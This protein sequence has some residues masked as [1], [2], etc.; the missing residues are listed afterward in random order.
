MKKMLVWVTQMNYMTKDLPKKCH[1]SFRWLN[2]VSVVRDTMME[3]IYKNNK[4]KCNLFVLA[5][6]L[7]IIL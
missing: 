4:M 7:S 2:T 5:D 6:I 1:V 3:R